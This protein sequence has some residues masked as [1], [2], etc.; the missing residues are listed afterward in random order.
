MNVL[1]TGGAGFIG[2]HIVDACIERGYKVA[3]VDSLLT[4]HRRN[5]NPSAA[6]Y[7]LD[8]RS[9]GLGDVFEETK[10]NVVF[11][12]AAQMNVTLS[13]KKPVIDADI[14]VV[15]TVNL[16]QNCADYGVERFIFSSTAGKLTLGSTGVYNLFSSGTIP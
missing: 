5:V 3:I 4:G 12:L 16:L 6:F 13:L 9:E 8:I 7:E 10:P 2:S 15:G 11:H 14:N 1:V